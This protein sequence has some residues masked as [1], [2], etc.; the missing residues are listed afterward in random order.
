MM[1]EKYEKLL[2]EFITNNEPERRFKRSGK[3]KSE[4]KHPS[5]NIKQLYK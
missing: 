3:S 1:D 5:I 2:A 4:A